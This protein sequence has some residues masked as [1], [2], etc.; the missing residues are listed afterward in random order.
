MVVVLSF[1]D[2][3]GWSGLRSVS[4]TLCVFLVR[5][6]LYVVLGDLF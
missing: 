6:V 1:Y 2:V 3:D 5:M 4:F